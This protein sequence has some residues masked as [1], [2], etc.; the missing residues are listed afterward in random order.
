VLFDVAGTL[1]E[2]RAPA[3]EFYA[4]VAQRYGVSISA[5][6]LT[7]AFQRVFSK[8]SP[9]LFPG[10]SASEVPVL[11]KQ[12][13]RARVRETFRAADGTAR[14]DDFEAYFE[15]LFERFSTT[16]VWQVI[17]GA[18][19]AL[20]A[21]QAL[22]LKLGVVSNFDY[23]LP[24]IL[25]ALGILSHFEFVLC[26][27]E[28]GAAK[29]DSRIFQAALDRLSMPPEQ[30]VFVGDH[31]DRDVRAARALGMRAIW[32]DSPATLRALPELIRGC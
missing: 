27:G 14:F 2:L 22:D 5:A 18:A 26:A 1:I 17:D 23:R 12:W 13:W 10:A 24:R 3:G 31:P 28:V 9:M 29:P 15:E 16:E 21:L 32:M 4:R 8:A 20:K 30:V 6:R 25:E 19:E 11:E 7:E